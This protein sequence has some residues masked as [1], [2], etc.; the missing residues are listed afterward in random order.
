LPKRDL[1]AQWAKKNDA[2]YYSYNNSINIDGDHGLIS[3]Y[4][5]SPA[6][7]HDNQMLPALIDPMNEQSLFYG[8]SAYACDIS[9]E[10]PFSC[11]L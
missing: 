6:N 5:V 1:D 7:I 4:D 9:E 3:K 11:W 8:D 10:F 2:S